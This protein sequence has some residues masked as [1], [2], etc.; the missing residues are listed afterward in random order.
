MAKTL[1][2]VFAALLAAAL[3]LGRSAAADSEAATLDMVIQTAFV[4]DVDGFCAAPIPIC[5]LTCDGTSIV[6]RCDGVA[7]PIDCVPIDTASLCNNVPYYPC[8]CV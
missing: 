3:P 7:C 4:Q 5:S 2:L 6:G 1:V 8:W